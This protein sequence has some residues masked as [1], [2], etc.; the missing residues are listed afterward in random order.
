MPGELI[1]LTSASHPF[2]IANS[3]IEVP[4]GL[5]LAEMLVVCQSDPYLR[6]YAVAMINGNII[7][8]EVWHV[9]RPNAG[10][11]VEIRVLPTGGG[12]GGS[13]KNILRIVLTLAVIVG[14]SFLGGPLGT[15]LGITA[16]QGSAII[17]AVGLLL[18]NVLV[19]VKP[20][21]L[22]LEERDPAFSI[23]G[24]RNRLTPFEPVPQI[25]GRHRIAPPFGAAP[26]TEIIGEDQFLT[27]LFV[28]SVGP[29]VL[30]ISSLKI[31]ETPLVDFTDVETEHRPGKPGD[32]ALTLFPDTV[33]QTDLTLLLTDAVFRQRTSAVDADELS[34]DVMWPQGL[35]N[36]NLSSGG[37]DP[38]TV[39]LQLNF[40]KV[41]DSTW[42]T[43]VFSAKTVADS[44]ISGDLITV[45][46]DTRNP[47]RHG[48]R[49]PVAT[50]GQY[51][52]RLRR[53]VAPTGKPDH[54]EDTYWQTI[55][56]ITNE[57]PI[58][59]AVPVAKTVLR[60]K[61]TD[62]LNRI[63]D[64][65]NGI[66]T[67]EGL[68]WNGATWDADQPIT[69]PASLFRHVLQGKA[70]A[71]P[72][73]EARLDLP[74]IQAFHLHCSTL[75]L[76]FNQVRADATS[77][78]DTL[79]DVCGA[80]R[81]APTQIDGKWS[82]VIEEAKATPVSH[83]TPRNSFG[84][85]S[86]KAF[87]DQPHA[88]RVQFPN[89]DQGYRSDERRVY[90]DG[91]TAA[92]ATKFEALQFPGVTDPEQIQK[93]GRF[94]IAQFINQ[95]ERWSFGMDLEYITF[96]RGARVLITHDVLL[97][98]QRSGRIKSVMVDGSTN[99][100]AV[101][102]DEQVTM[103]A[104]TNYGISIRTVA[105]AEVTRQVVTVAGATRD[106]TLTTSIPPVSGDP[107]V[108][109]GDLFGFG[110]LGSETDDATIIAIAPDNEFRARII[111]V[112][113]RD[114]IFNIDDDETIPPF[115]TNLTPLP[116]IPAPRVTSVTSDETAIILGPGQSLQTRV[117]VTFDPL[118]DPRLNE[119]TV[120]V[121][122]RTSAGGEPFQAVEIQQ[123][124]PHF[125]AIAGMIDGSTVDI[126]LR[127]E[128][129]GR[130]PGPFVTI[131]NHTVVGKSTPPGDLTGLTITVMGGQAM[132]RWDPPN[133]IDV[134]FGGEVRFRHSPLLTGA[135]WQNSVSIGQAARARDLI[136]TLPL[137]AG[138]YLA[139]VFD[140][141]GN[142]SDGIASV[143]TKQASVDLFGS[144]GA[145][146]EDPL[147]AGTH[148]GTV[149]VD[150]ILQLEGITQWDSFA[151]LDLVPDIDG[152]GGIVSTGTYNW[153][154]KI[155]LTT[156][157]RVRLTTRITAISINPNDLI[158]DRTEL[159]DTW[160]DFDG[161]EQSATD[162]KIQVRNTDDDPNG[163]PAWSAYEQLEAA[164]F[165][166]RGFDLRVILTTTD[167]AFNIQISDLAVDVEELT[168]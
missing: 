106:L 67:T 157:K 21:S 51:E 142:R 72:L 130:L 38:F 39:T 90:R 8:R 10:T 85:G 94:R 29:I 141:S 93:L 17:S 92:N 112:P 65:F 58:K 45:K 139:R 140:S 44:T 168:P 6:R 22:D 153:Q 149:A 81:G 55:R 14:A 126:R 56:T 125:V 79:Q 76:T 3:T 15:V 77:V 74:G 27:L 105:D 115:V 118:D 127:F 57:D 145:F 158:D 154:N 155:D 52:V 119:P 70:F 143:T 104:G 129:E 110:I 25:L 116:V 136:A 165:E 97:V 152:A 108:A 160:E 89:E 11:H 134:Q 96:T 46:A 60:I 47:I 78:W 109:A 35:T 147:F 1:T 49:W 132:L 9:V 84:F 164:E 137:K 123:R 32:A 131:F 42:L 122:A 63:I 88:W 41:G 103:V 156:V 151:D 73:A 40:R 144:L 100:T 37:S 133:E 26:F 71:T 99:V 13:R 36:L 75:G 82:V 166:A 64:E 61:A 87:I 101:S 4:E 30:D 12:G 114:V 121:Q 148:S 146:D 31:G 68:D 80:G 28:W 5:T 33:V 117:I 159:I 128:V 98:G 135:L 50:R 69:N 150:G 48:F 163:A 19:P 62:Q 18:I 59:S 124:D 167:P 16:L 107:A 34:I 120:F 2:K 7:P 24:S 138:T 102:L 53:T 20:P 161:I 43:P 23:A 83:V 113:Y 111:A 66:I 162:A 91:F 95:P 54:I 86:E